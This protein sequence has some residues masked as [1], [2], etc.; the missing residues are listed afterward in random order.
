MGCYNRKPSFF[1]IAVR[2]S[3]LLTGST[4]NAH[5]VTIFAWVEGETIYTKSKFSGGKKVV[6]GDILV[7]D[8]HENRLL[9]GK[10]DEKGE[11]SFKVPK[12]EALKVVL[13]AGAGHRGEWMIP[14]DEIQPG[15]TDSVMLVQDKNAATAPATPGIEGSPP[16][17]S[18][19]LSREM[20]RQ[21]WKR[22]LR[23]N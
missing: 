5:R 19:R 15:S 16:P 12:K 17:P 21:L 18:E 11:F 1:S 2:I 8:A 3:I 10:T 9:T 23:E 4:A 22:P 14:A 20:W 6:G 13:Q 7:Y